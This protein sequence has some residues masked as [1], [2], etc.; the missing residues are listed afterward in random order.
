MP[1]DRDVHTMLLRVR[2]LLGAHPE[3]MRDYLFYR[4]EVEFQRDRLD[5]AEQ[6][7]LKRFDRFLVKWRAWIVREVY[8]EA[9]LAEARDQFGE[10]HWWWRLK[11]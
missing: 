3:I 6:K 11:D 4:S 9:T 2:P 7:A 8:D 10:G 5:E 1:A